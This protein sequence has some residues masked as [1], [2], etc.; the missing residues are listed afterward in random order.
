MNTKA[1]WISAQIAIGAEELVG[2]PF[3]LYG[4]DPLTGFD[5]VGVVCH[6]LTAAGLPLPALPAYRLR[7]CR[8]GELVHRMGLAGLRPAADHNARIGDIAMAIPGPAQLHMLVRVS[9]DSFVHAHAGL[10]R[11]VSTPAPCPWPVRHIFRYF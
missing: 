2:A 8:D 9:G 4:R 11:V 10:R 3:R 6:A 1:A 7:G 5:C